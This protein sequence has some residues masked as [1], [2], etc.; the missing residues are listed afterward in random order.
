MKIHAIIGGTAGLGGALARLLAQSGDAI[1]LADDPAA[2]PNVP[3]LPQVTFHP[4]DLT[5]PAAP[6]AFADAIAQRHGRLDSLVVAAS[7]MSQAPLPEWQIA[8][9][10]RAAAI[11]LRLPFLAAQAMQT[12]LVGSKGSLVL[13]SSTATLRG[14]PQTHAYQ[15]TKAGL[16]GLMRSL[17]SELGPL[18]V[19][20]NLV[21]PGWVD[22]AQTRAFWDAQA[23]AGAARAAVEARIP[24]RRHGSAAEVAAALAWLL[25]DAASYVTGAMLPLDGGDTAV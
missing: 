24:L 3:A 16:A 4:L 15:A 23:D 5:D 10:D 18:G 9:W 8:D 1:W 19:R 13:V 20:V 14:Q 2:A 22:T 6:Q 11:N 12:L 17:A 25:S 21:L 7:A